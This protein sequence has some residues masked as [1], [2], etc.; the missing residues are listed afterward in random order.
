[1]ESRLIIKYRRGNS[2]LFNFNSRRNPTIN[3]NLEKIVSIFREKDDASVT[4]VL[5]LR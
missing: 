1:M 2:V 3:K 5:H 4:W